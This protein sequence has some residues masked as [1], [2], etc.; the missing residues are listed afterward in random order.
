LKLEVAPVSGTEMQDLV[1][2]LYAA[3]PDVVELVKKIS[4]AQ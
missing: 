1:S 4:S 2:E 3:P